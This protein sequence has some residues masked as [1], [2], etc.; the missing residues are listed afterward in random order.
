[1]AP[2]GTCYLCDREELAQ[3]RGAMTA[4]GRPRRLDVPGHLS[5]R[6]KNERD[7]LL[8]RTSTFTP[9]AAH[10]WEVLA[11]LVTGRT[12]HPQLFVCSSWL[13]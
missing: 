11:T 7:K 12:S 3:Q 9:R 2:L 6:R 5:S 13:M 8:L 4:P 10:G 1:M